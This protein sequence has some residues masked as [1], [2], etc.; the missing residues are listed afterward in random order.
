MK[1]IRELR[2]QRNITAKQLGAIINVAESTM[3]LYENGKRN[4]DYETLR[5]LADYFD[6]STD[7]LLGRSEVQFPSP[8]ASEENA[9]FPVI[10]DI[11]AGFDSIGLESWDGDTVEIPVSYFKTKKKEDFFVLRVKGDSM[12]PEYK[13][14][15]KVLIKKQNALDYNGQIAA[16]LYDDELATLKRIEYRPGELM[17][18]IPINPLVPPIKLEGE[19]L[20]HCRIIGIPKVLIRDIES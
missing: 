3:S 2:K 4:P 12:Y 19:R 17:R 9:V 6:V 7:Y 18:L 14:G 10:G 20:N 13:E 8:I 5:K 1:T 15:D 11:A 16:V